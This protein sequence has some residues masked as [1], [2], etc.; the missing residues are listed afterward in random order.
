MSPREA[1]A[2]WGITERRVAALCTAGRVEGAEKRGGRWAIP[3]A[4]EKPGDGRI[5]TGR[6]RKAGAEEGLPLPR[7]VEN[8]GEAAGKYRLLDKSRFILELQRQP[9]KISV[10]ARPAG[11]GKSLLLTMLRE[12]LETAPRKENDPFLTLGVMSGGIAAGEL[13]GSAPAV[14]LRF[15]PLLR[16]G[17]RGGADEVLRCVLR[18]FARHGE[19]L[20]AARPEER[21]LLQALREGGAGP[22][23][24]RQAVALLLRLVQRQSGKTPWLLVDD[25]DAPARM[26][27]TE[28]EKEAALS[29]LRGM[30]NEALRQGKLYKRAVLM[31]VIPGEGLAYTAQREGA[32]LYSRE[33]GSFRDSFGF[34]EEELRRLCAGEG[35]RRKIREAGEWYGSMDGGDLRYNCRSVLEYLARGPGQEEQ[36]TALLEAVLAQAGEDTLYKTAELLAGKSVSVCVAPLSPAL[37]LPERCSAVMGLM[38]AEGLLEMESW[39]PQPRGERLCRVRLCNKSAAFRL[40]QAVLAATEDLFPCEGVSRVLEAL[41]TGTRRS[42]AKAVTDLLVRCAAAQEGRGGT[43]YAACLAGMAAIGGDDCPVEGEELEEGLILE[44]HPGRE[45]LSCVQAA[46]CV[47]KNP[48][49]DEGL[50]KKAEEALA[51]VDRIYEPEEN[52]LRL[53]VAGAGKRAGAAVDDRKG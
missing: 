9:E 36:N 22:E 6:Y 35:A 51:L 1:A 23:E 24:R 48:C 13:R 53:G 33:D 31:G 40:R 49:G 50:K 8:W 28:R 32:R 19:A 2:F 20:G 25:F 21:E 44:L 5:K 14:W 43:F 26:E 10:I 17:G 27:G 15:G 52:C 11:S 38:L 34:N 46:V 47:Q 16:S 18:E 42:A 41:A 45:D 7:G 39:L 12:Y 30:L 3:G 37:P 4:L 29:A